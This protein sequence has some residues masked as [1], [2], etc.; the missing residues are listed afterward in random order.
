MYKQILVALDASPADEAIINHIAELAPIHHSHVILLRVAHYHTRD[1][2]QHEVEESEQYLDTVAK[3][4]AERGVNVETAVSHGEPAEQI[5][6][7]AESRG[8]DL[9]AMSTHGHRG[10]YDLVFGS[11]AEE[12]R[13]V[14]A[15]PVLLVR[16][17]GELKV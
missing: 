3:Q 4:L 11:V 17:T 5:V 16:Y 13:H 7:E 12:V 14:V 15:I 6:H 10:L 8:V 2:M 1:Q 9:I